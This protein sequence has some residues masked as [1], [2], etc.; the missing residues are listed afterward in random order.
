V[1]SRLIAG[2]RGRLAVEEAG[3]G[4]PAVVFVHADL[5]TSAQWARAQ[6]HV[7]ES[8]RA[9]ALDLRGHGA[10]DPPADGDYSY[11]GR[12]ADVGAVLDALAVGRAVLVGHSGGAT[13]ALHY[14]S[15]HPE[16]VEALLLVD[17]PSDGRQFPAE[18]KEAHLAQLRSPQFREATRAYYGS[19]AGHDA[20]V[21]AQVLG[22]ADRTPQATIVGT[23]EALGAYDPGP[24]LRGYR[25]RRLA[26]VTP[27][28]DLPAALYR[29]DPTLPHRTVAGT[30]HWIHL[31]DPEGFERTLDEFIAT[32]R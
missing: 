32:A 12:A 3:V 7:A 11:A 28:G 23:M 5:G 17:P 18:Q 21:R 16:R 8:R 9:V 26:L 24:A 19:I 1:T 4:E 2:P 6:A 10:S 27:L 22:D 31:D 25:G 13:T 20:A 29:V 14:A 15:T 30:G